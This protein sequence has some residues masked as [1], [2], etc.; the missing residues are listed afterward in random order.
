MYGKN[1]YINPAI[2][3]AKLDVGFSTIPDQKM[4]DQLLP[5]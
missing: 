2:K 5:I 1:K 4:Q 3:V